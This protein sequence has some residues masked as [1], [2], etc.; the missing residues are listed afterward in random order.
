MVYIDKIFQ[1]TTILH[2]GIPQS[3]FL[4]LPFCDHIPKLDIVLVNRYICV[5]K[6]KSGQD[7]LAYDGDHYRI[8]FYCDEKGKSQSKDYVQEKLQED[9]VWKFVQL[10]MMM[11]DLGQI[12]NK[13]KFRNEGDKIYAF[14]PQPHR[15]LCFFFEGRK[16]IITNAFMKKQQKLPSGEK[17][18]ALKCMQ[19]YY[20]RVKKDKYYGSEDKK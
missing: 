17:E 20:D 1:P 12:R 8:E 15:F 3:L 16:I 14:K 18:K 5:M 19:D 7:Y 9:D 11:G 6:A 2:N 10:L 4:L 13:E